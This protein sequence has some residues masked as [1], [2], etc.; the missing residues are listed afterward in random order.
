MMQARINTAR[1]PIPLWNW[2]DIKAARLVSGIT[3]ARG[4]VD[5]IDSVGD[6]LHVGNI[7]PYPPP[8]VT[9]WS[10]LCY[11]GSRTYLNKS[12]WYL[13]ELTG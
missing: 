4:T 10:Q 12:V 1:L 3:S 13:F 6:L 9:K 11:I 5:V 7:G 2:R 8:C